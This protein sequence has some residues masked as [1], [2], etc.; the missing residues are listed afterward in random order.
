MHGIKEEVLPLQVT[1]H[2]MLHAREEPAHLIV[3][4]P[5]N[6]PQCNTV[7]THA[8]KNARNAN[9]LNTERLK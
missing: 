4:Q 5:L 9:T 6:E 1:H 8:V 7:I 2:V 3:S